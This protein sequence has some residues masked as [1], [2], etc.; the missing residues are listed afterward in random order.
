MLHI[1]NMRLVGV[2][3]FVAL[4]APAWAADAP[5]HIRGTLTEVQA[6]QAVVQT[7]GGKSETFKLNDKTGVFIVAPADFSAITPNKFIGVTSVE[8]DGKRIAREVHVFADSLR[9]LAEGHYPWDLESD[10]NMMTNANI[11]KVEQVGAD[12]VLKLDYKGG[13]Q[14]VSLPASATIVSFDKGTADQMK[15]G[16]KVFVIATPVEDPAGTSAI[17]VVVGAGGLKPPM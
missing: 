1:R 6:T 17:I 13:E 2:A 10:A 7:A 14:T 9:G 15:V 11:G 4:A 12:H 16:A 5:R 3:A 8:K